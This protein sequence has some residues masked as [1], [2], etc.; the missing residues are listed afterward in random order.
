[1]VDANGA[2][3]MEHMLTS[4]YVA[5]HIDGHDYFYALSEVLDGAQ[6]CIFILVR[7]STLL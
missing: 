5:R 3:V 4:I 1:M 6:D 2:F 7:S